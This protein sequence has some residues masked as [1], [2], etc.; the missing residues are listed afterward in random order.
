MFYKYLMKDHVRV[1]PH[2]F[3]YDVQE[4]IKKALEEKYLGLN[5]REIGFVVA[6][7]AVQNIGEGFVISGDGAVYYPCEFEIYAYKSLLQE[8]VIGRILDITEFGAFISIGPF[9]GMIHISQT[10][11]DV[12]TFS[13]S[14]VLSGK[15]TKRSLKIGDVVLARIIAISLKDIMNPKIGLTMR[16]PYLGKEEW[17]EDEKSV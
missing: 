1:P 11:N 15:N 2:L 10:M 9:D 8:A 4:S 5:D 7:G 14:Q 12:V 17:W 16:Q 6:I 3:N 13:K